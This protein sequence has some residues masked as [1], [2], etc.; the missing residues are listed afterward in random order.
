[1]RRMKQS[2]RNERLCLSQVAAEVWISRDVVKVV[3]PE[4]PRRED[5]TLKEKKKKR[6]VKNVST[7]RK[8][9]ETS[10]GLSSPL[11]MTTK[12]FFSLLIEEISNVFKP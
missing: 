2:G 4:C 7:P 1:M 12:D 5:V 6:T 8:D 11:R 9:H 10:V 3:V